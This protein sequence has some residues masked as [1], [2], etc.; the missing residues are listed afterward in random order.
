M[1]DVA[2]RV[3]STLRSFSTTAV[4]AV[5]AVSLG[6]GAL[7]Y[8]GSAMWQVWLA[9]VALAIGIPHGAMDHLVTVPRMEPARMALFISG[10]LGV[11]AVVVWAI[12]TW[13]VAGF[14]LVVVMSAVHFGVGDAAFLSEKRRLAGDTKPTAPWF[15]YALPAGMLPVVIPLTSPG[16]DEAL[17][18]V[19]PSLVGWH[20][21]TG[22]FFLYASVALALLGMGWLI[23]IRRFRDA[24]DLLALLGL[25]LFV[26][27]LVAFSVYFGLWHA[28][29]HTG[30]LTLEL[31]R[32]QEHFTASKPV[33]G[34]F[35]AVIPGLPAL[36]GTMAVALALTVLG[37]WDVAETYFWFALVVVWALTVPHMALTARL[38]AK[39]LAPTSTTR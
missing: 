7:G 11:V 3:F 19:N 30:R 10:Y 16:A 2:L 28:L 12:L 18:L 26:P 13:N 27:P 15:V 1:A 9:I 8:S 37:G 14:A 32:A 36:V 29:R 6:L 25:A 4:L 33:R 17:G 22:P 39:A 34:F 31:P 21:G 35:A 24:L 20:Q 38:D 5:I 23:A